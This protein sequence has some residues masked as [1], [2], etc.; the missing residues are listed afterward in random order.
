ML[1]EV[2]IPSSEPMLDL[3]LGR[4]G[5]LVRRVPARGVGGDVR[6][7]FV[8]GGGRVCGR[9]AQGEARRDG[10]GLAEAI[11][12]LVHLTEKDVLGAAA[13]QVVAAELHH[14]GKWKK[15]ISHFFHLTFEA[16]L[17]KLKSK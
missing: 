4:L 13:H 9:G 15:L 3:F 1:V 5:L 11:L 12:H 8:G 6:Q 2:K 17:L 7:R 16:G 10:R 14:L